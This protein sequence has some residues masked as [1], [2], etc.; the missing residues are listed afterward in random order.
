[1]QNSFKGERCLGFIHPYFALFV[2]LFYDLCVQDSDD[3]M[4]QSSVLTAVSEPVD[5]KVSES[6]RRV[7]FLVALLSYRKRSVANLEYFDLLSWEMLMSV[8]AA[9]CFL[10]EGMEGK[11][12]VSFFCCKFKVSYFPPHCPILV[13]I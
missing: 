9:M 2:G 4:S 7:C 1:M 8:I 10:L 5:V 3:N 13:L 12:L 6:G 11:T